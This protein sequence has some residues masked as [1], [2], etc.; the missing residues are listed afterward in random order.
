M[1]V[2]GEEEEERLVEDA[3][4]FLPDDLIGDPSSYTVVADEDRG[5]SGR[6]P[7]L[8]LS[9]HFDEGVTSYYGDTVVP[10]FS[11]EGIAVAERKRHDFVMTSEL[12]ATAESYV[13]RRIVESSTAIAQQGT[14]KE[15]Q[16]FAAKWLNDTLQSWTR[17][18]AP[19]YFGSQTSSIEAFPTVEVGNEKANR[20]SPDSSRWPHP[21]P[22]SQSFRAPY[23]SDGLWKGDSDTK[24]LVSES[25]VEEA[26][27]SR[28]NRAAT[29]TRSGTEE[30]AN[31][32]VTAPSERIQ[33]DRK[34]PKG[35][36]VSNG[37]IKLSS[38]AKR[39]VAVETDSRTRDTQISDELLLQS[40]HP[41]IGTGST[42][43]LPMPVASLE[44]DKVTADAASLDTVG[45]KHKQTDSTIAA[46]IKTGCTG[47]EE[48]LSQASAVPSAR[49]KEGV[50]TRPH[51]KASN[52][53]L[54]ETFTSRQLEFAASPKVNK[55]PNK[56]TGRKSRAKRS[57]TKSVTKKQD[58]Q[59]KFQ[60]KRDNKG[61]TRARGRKG[62]VYRKSEPSWQELSKLKLATLSDNIWI[63][64]LS[65]ATFVQGTWLT[66]SDICVGLGRCALLPLRLQVEAVQLVASES[67]VLL[68]YLAFYLY[69]LICK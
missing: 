22:A 37:S 1:N 64:R 61:S 57:L 7:T 30:P 45:K 53:D 31:S 50:R 9:S 8:S 6:P 52:S 20:R 23:L 60:R 4:Y 34:G 40:R 65:F 69:P 2:D 29:S 58:G 5:D 10:G 15:S 41:S 24:L 28:S 18:S 51:R 59:E 12:R 56:G 3:R 17:S 54:D 55:Q 44:N 66:F 14:L 42:M 48:Q 49:A 67:L 19:Q 46:K 47:I 62:R 32:L 36:T 25:R 26:V 16:S 39:V 33:I 27:T 68:C 13:P 35:K 63:P 21:E 38:E 11:T 43:K